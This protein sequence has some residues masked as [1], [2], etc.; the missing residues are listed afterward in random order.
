LDILGDSKYVNIYES[1]SVEL[2]TIQSNNLQPI[3]TSRRKSASQSQ[4]K[5]KIHIVSDALLNSV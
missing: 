4:Q 2:S 1:A 5:G 3:D